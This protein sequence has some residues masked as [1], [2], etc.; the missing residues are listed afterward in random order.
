[1]ASPEAAESLGGGVS[2]VRTV[3]SVPLFSAHRS[4]K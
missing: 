2:N 4:H 3:N 1:V